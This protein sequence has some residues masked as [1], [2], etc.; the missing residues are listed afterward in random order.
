MERM[1]GE[2]FDA[3]P[4]MLLAVDRSHNNKKK[5]ATTMMNLGPIC[6]KLV[7]IFEA[8]HKT[9]HM[10]LDVKPEN[11]M[12]A[13]ATNA[14]STT[15]NPVDPV[16]AVAD[17]IRVVDLGLVKM[18]LGPDGHVPDTGS[19]AVQGTP[20]YASHTVHAHH[21]PSR[22][23]DMESLVYVLG[24][25]VLTLLSVAAA[26]NKK[27]RPPP[28]SYVRG[29]PP[30]TSSSFLPWSQDGSDEAMG[31]TKEK[32]VG[33]NTESEYYKAMPPAA[34]GI[35]FA[36]LKVVRGC[37]YA[38]KPP[39]AVLR[40]LL[41][42]LAIPLNPTN[43]NNNVENTNDGGIVQKKSS[44]PTKKSAVG[45]IPD[46]YDD[47]VSSM[48]TTVA[49]VSTMTTTTT[50][51]TSPL[52]RSTRHAKSSSFGDDDAN[53]VPNHNHAM[54]S[55]SESS[56]VV[57]HDDDNDV[58]MQD[59]VPKGATKKRSSNENMKPSS[60]III[61]KP[62]KVSRRDADKDS[63]APETHVDNTL[64]SNTK[65]NRRHAA[66]IRM[67]KGSLLGKEHRLEMDTPLVIGSAPSRRGGGKFH[68]WSISGDAQISP[69][70]V[71]LELKLV[72]GIVSVQVTDLKSTTGT[73][74][75][76]RQIPSGKGE[77]VFPGGVRIRCG[78]QELKVLKP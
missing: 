22:R 42:T 71:M 38:K 33:I 25:L 75:L 11:L 31:R 58:I 1:E 40:T 28:P 2:L 69:N 77:R 73:F 14:A 53:G 29:S 24:D 36:A 45:N 65:P 51:S 18:F 61:Q 5:P 34:A 55:G 48:T 19:A 50:T 74:I 47:A 72:S 56:K 3:L 43:N 76:N 64:E 46:K 16:A 63:A 15:T 26:H 67:T 66:L 7:D 17:R 62:S 70:H 37:E 32:H 44:T 57:M 30:A 12:V 35:L 21:T 6:G 68:G 39:Y 20:L 49:T 8:I 60:A 4:A 10:L 41:S 52:R 23:D 27:Q 9:G 54:G 78:D 13:F 59:A